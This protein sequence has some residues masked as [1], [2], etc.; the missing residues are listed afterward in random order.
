M[1][2]LESRIII[3]CQIPTQA[4]L[5][6]EWLIGNGYDYGYDYVMKKMRE[7][8]VRGLVRLLKCPNERKGIKCDGILRPANYGKSL[9]CSSCGSAFTIN[10]G[11]NEFDRTNI[12]SKNNNNV[13]GPVFYA[14]TSLGIDLAEKFLSSPSQNVS[15]TTSNVQR[16]LVDCLNNK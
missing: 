16:Q 6:W 14:S 13:G 4:S 15:T 8:N 7:M 3:Y 9:R 10:R 12:R 2:E 5:I 1:N 11:D